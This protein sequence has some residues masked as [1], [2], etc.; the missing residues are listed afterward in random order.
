MS[1][2]DPIRDRNKLSRLADF[3]LKRGEFR[4]YLLIIFGTCT[5]LR[6]SDLLKLRWEDVYDFEKKKY[7]HHI[8]LTEKKTGKEKQVALNRDL[9]NALKIGF[10]HRNGN[11][12]FSNGRKKENH[13]SRAHAY[14][15]IKN[16]AKEVGIEGTIGCHSLR[17]TFG[18]FAWKYEK[19][20]VAL[21]MEIY[22]HSS[23]STTKRYLGIAQDDVNQVY[24]NIKFGFKSHNKSFPPAH[25]MRQ[26][27]NDP[28]AGKPIKYKPGR[29]NQKNKNSHKKRKNK[30][31]W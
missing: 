6:I 21:L 27:E 16:A 12:I 18:Y 22:N 19:I 10:Q 11:Y 14:R 9:I 5:A 15:I 28:M 1:K 24:L 13:I 4:N 17:K 2:T 26:G 3:F 25:C 20:S 23:E 8:F 29:I 31:M 30:I 7:R